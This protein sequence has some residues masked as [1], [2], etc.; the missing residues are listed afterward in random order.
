MHKDLAWV[1]NVNLQ[2][3]FI[4]N[5]FPLLLLLNSMPLT[6]KWI[7]SLVPIRRVSLFG[8]TQKYLNKSW[9]RTDPCRTHKSISL[10]ELC[11]LFILTICLL[12]VKYES[13]PYTLSVAISKSSDKQSNDFKKSVKIAPKIPPWSR[14]SLHFSITERKVANIL[15]SFLN[16][17]WYGDKTDSYCVCSWL[18]K[19]LSYIL[20]MLERILTG[21]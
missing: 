15:R 21:Q 8:F 11:V 19:S 14:D 5:S 9:K 13:N 12:F 6:F 20:E 18:C 4:T 10:Q 2:T 1:S 17:H 7:S 3:N 16:P